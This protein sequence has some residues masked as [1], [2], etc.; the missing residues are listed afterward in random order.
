MELGREIS[1]K[2]NLRNWAHCLRLRLL[3][4]TKSAVKLP[5]VEMKG[6]VRKLAR[7][8]RKLSPVKCVELCSIDKGGLFVIMVI[9]FKAQ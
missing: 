4:A 3:Q 5:Y 1:G 2:A 9:G 7:E 8:E 6:V